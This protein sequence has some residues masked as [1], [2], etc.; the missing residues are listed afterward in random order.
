[1]SIHH[2]SIDVTFP[3]R[4]AKFKISNNDELK[5]MYLDRIIQSYE[6]E[7]YKIPEGWFTKSICT[8]HALLNDFQEQIVRPVPE[9]YMECLNECIAEEWNGNVYL[10]HNVIKN[11]EYQEVHNHLPSF[12]SAIHFLQFDKNEHDL[13]VFLDPGRGAKYPR[14]TLDT[15][16]GGDPL[17]LPDV[18]EGDII[19]FPSY[20]DHFV[21][22][23]KYNNYRVTVSFN[24]TLN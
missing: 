10:W 3:T 20:L 18:E 17:F 16:L 1:M 22:G 8:S 7:E 23:G 24:L 11:G 12:L 14:H 2:K 5:E 19:V 9:V 21:S 6:N 13:P 4:M 15:Y